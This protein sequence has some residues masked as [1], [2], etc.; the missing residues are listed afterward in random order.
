VAN[1]WL[2]TGTSSGL[3]RTLTELALERG[4]CVPRRRDAATRIKIRQMAGCA[5][6]G[7]ERVPVIDPLS[8]RAPA[9][10]VLAYSGATSGRDGGSGSP[11]DA[12]WGRRPLRARSLIPSRA[13]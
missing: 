3:G 8:L 11:C 13:T 2:I 12:G 6:M 9:A 5:E 7:P 4:R 10:A 1:N